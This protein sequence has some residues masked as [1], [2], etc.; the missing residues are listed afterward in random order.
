M[1]IIP[2]MNSGIPFVLNDGRSLEIVPLQ[3]F[4]SASGQTAIR[5]GRNILFFNEN[6]TFDGTEAR[7]AEDISEDE[8]DT[9]VA[10]LESSKTTDGV[11]PAEPYFMVGSDGYDAETRAWS[12]SKKLALP[13]EIEESSTYQI[14]PHGRSQPMKK[15]PTH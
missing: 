6:G 3:V 10:A 15:K 7:V 12:N 4:R 14:D 2:C 9:L 13:E 11:A 8:C 5:I 1:K